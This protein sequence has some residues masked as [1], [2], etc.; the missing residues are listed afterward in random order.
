MQKRWGMGSLKLLTSF[1]G[2]GRESESHNV[3]DAVISSLL[4]NSRTVNECPVC[5]SLL[6][7]LIFHGILH[8]FLSFLSII[9][10]E[11][12]FLRVAIRRCNDP[13]MTQGTQAHPLLKITSGIGSNVSPVLFYLSA[14]NLKE[15][16]L[17]V[18][19]TPP[20]YAITSLERFLHTS[21]QCNE[22]P[23]YPPYGS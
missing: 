9:R 13:H 7:S 12:R 10:A 17:I 16:R 1:R 14:P 23:R 2:H 21:V 8:R 11:L 20:I 19:Q 22:T 18:D 6:R 15:R 5:F 3:D 4:S